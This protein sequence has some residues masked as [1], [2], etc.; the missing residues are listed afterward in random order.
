[1]RLNNIIIITINNSVEISRTLIKK[2]GPIQLDTNTENMGEM[3]I[4]LYQS[5]P[6]LENCFKDLALD[7]Q[8]LSILL[9]YTEDTSPYILQLEIPYLYRIMLEGLSH[10]FRPLSIIGT[11]SNRPMWDIVDP[12]IVLKFSY[13]ICNAHI[14]PKQSLVDGN[15][16]KEI[17]TPNEL[18]LL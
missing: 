10:D 16:S 7:H 8:H 11:Y 14:Y 1:M 17:K 13:P 2:M 4:E 6:A 18:I 15:L 9:D 5:F 12:S 3:E